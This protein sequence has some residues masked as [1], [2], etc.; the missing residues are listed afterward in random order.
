MTAAPDPAIVSRLR[1]LR[2]RIARDP[3]L[4]ID[5]RPFLDAAEWENDG[6]GTV[7]GRS[8]HRVCEL[9]STHICIGRE[10]FPERKR[11]PW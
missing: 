9:T 11:V 6:D 8:G 4:G 1:K 5:V 2:E 3:V 10:G 7:T